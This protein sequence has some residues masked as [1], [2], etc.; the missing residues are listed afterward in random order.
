MNP[1]LQNL[2]FFPGLGKICP[3]QQC[4]IPS[5]KH[6]GPISSTFY[7]IGVMVIITSIV[8]LSD[9]DV[10]VDTTSSYVPRN[11]TRTLRTG[12][13]ISIPHFGIVDSSRLEGQSETVGVSR[14]RVSLLSHTNEVLSSH[15]N[16]SVD[17]GP[18]VKRKDPPCYMLPI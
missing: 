14:S 17:I 12:D 7:S 18:K 5:N 15:M 1:L 8:S 9:S 13:D 10:D 3:G 2:I 6:L 16:S 11:E 4:F